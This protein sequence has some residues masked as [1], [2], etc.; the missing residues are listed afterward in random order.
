M[1]IVYVIGFADAW[2][3][4]AKASIVT[5]SWPSMPT[6]AAAWYCDMISSPGFMASIR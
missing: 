4:P 6:T 1:P 2:P 3:L 5:V